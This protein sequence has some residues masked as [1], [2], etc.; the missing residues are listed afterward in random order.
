[1]NNVMSLLKKLNYEK[2][3]SLF[4]LIILFIVSSIA[5]PYFLQIQNIL[6]ILRQV[7]Y[8]GIIALG[9]TF[10]IIGGGIDLSVG[11]MTALIGGIIILV[12][13]H[14][15]GDIGAIII[16]ILFGLFLG[17][18]GGMINGLLITKGKIA[19]FIVTLGT[20][21]IF[22]SLTLY[23]SNAGEF[24]SISEIYPSIG[25]G[26]FLFIPI[27]IWIFIGLAIVFHIIL[28]NT[29]YGRYIC[30]VGSN[31]K[32]AQYATINVDRIRL[33]SY[34][35][36]GL[37]VATSS[38]LLSSRLNSISSS[39]AGLN[40]ELDAISAVI[41]GGAPMVGGSGSISGTIF[42]AII[43]GIINNML[44]MIG[45]SPYLQG[46]VKGLVIIGA[47]LLQRGKR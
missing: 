39:N 6:N 34:I 47:V 26:S 25:M 11:S 21:A 27:P 35:I 7:S 15:G 44:N 18:V 20:M 16:S 12:L 5:S 19:P 43:L 8:T 10:V 1:M 32:V 22:R 42:G 38:V 31:E 37:S 36:V 41:I 4:T 24:R 46:T 30:A 33:I 17:I 2:Y 28:N 40:F 23:I 9:M 13:N 3:G 45:V 14:F 29:R